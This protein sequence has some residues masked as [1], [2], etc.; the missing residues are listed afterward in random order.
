M[1]AKAKTIPYRMSIITSFHNQEIGSANKIKNATINPA[2]SSLLYGP[3]VRLIFL[4]IN[5]EEYEGNVF[6]KGILHNI[7]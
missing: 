1:I 6:C 3:G 7:K 2:N 5:R 4:A